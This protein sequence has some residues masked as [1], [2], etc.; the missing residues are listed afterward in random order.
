[1]IK[2]SGAEPVPATSLAIVVHSLGKASETFIN[3]HIE[4]LAPGRTLVFCRSHD[5]ADLNAEII[6][7]VPHRRA[8]WAWRLRKLAALSGVVT[9]DK[10][11][12]LDSR[13]ADLVRRTLVDRGCRTVMAEYGFNGCAVAESV[14]AAGASLYV[15]FHGFDATQLT[16]LAICR[17]HYRALAQRGAG[18]ITPSRYI[19]D[20]LVDKGF[21]AE[22]LHVVPAPSSDG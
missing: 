15:Y 12:A 4:G 13:Q 22:R 9:A 5:R 3:A 7:L 6:N 1:L 18:F 11:W 14:N 16:R 10:R 8:R 17:R 2:F 21:P 19:A 20:Q